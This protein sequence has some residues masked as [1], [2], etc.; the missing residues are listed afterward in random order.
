MVPAAADPVHQ[1]T[2]PALGRLFMTPEQRR[3]L[4]TQRTGPASQDS[5]VPP[6]D[7]LPSGTASGGR[8][9]LNGVVRR[10][11]GGPVVWV[12]GREIDAA[13]S[14]RSRV[15]L[16]H[17]PDA[18]NRVTLEEGDDGASARLKPGQAWDPAS[19]R[20]SDCAQCGAVASRQQP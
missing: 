18:Q 2:L 9:V 13:T 16:R 5:S 20:I 4:D 15:H 19:G 7:M 11:A 10:A 17:G 6:A 1:A 12:N 3:L 14:A 8:V